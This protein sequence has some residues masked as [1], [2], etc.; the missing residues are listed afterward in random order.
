[1]NKGSAAAMSLPEDVTENPAVQARRCR[2]LASNMTNQSDIDLLEH[3]ADEY[4]LQADAAS[5]SS[6]QYSQRPER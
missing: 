1:M 5:G 2:K 6:A 3:M 4:D